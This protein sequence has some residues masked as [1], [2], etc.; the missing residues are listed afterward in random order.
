LEN[1]RIEALDT[2]LRD[3]AQCEGVSFSHDDMLS[4]AK[5]LDDFGITYIEA[6]C[7]DKSDL[8][9]F[10]SGLKL[11]AARLCAF[12]STRR[13]DCDCK[14]DI[15]L[16][17]LIAANTDTVSIVGKTWDFQVKEILK[18][19]LDENI[20][21]IGSSVK[22]LKSFKKY[23]IFDAEHFFDAY[24]NN[25]LYALK[26]IETAVKASA[27]LI[28]L[29]D[30][31]GG[32]HPNKIAAIVKEICGLYPDK[33]IGIHCHNDS[34]FAVINTVIAVENGATHIQGTFN[35]IGERCGNANLSSIIP[36]L[37]LKKGY[38]I[39]EPNKMQLLTETAAK[40]SD[41]SNLTLSPYSP[42]VGTSAFTHKAGLHA[43]GVLKTAASFE[44]L[45]PE[46][47]GNERRFLISELSGRN[48]IA[49]KIIKYFPHL[50]S[51][52]T[53]L[54]RIISKLKEIENPDYLFESAEASFVLKIRRLLFDYKEAFS[55]ES[56][57]TKT[58][59]LSVDKTPS[60]AKVKITVSDKT[61]VFNAFGKGPVDA[62]NEAFKKALVKFYPDLNKLTLTDYK[63]RVLDSKAATK[64][65]VR[66]LITT[67]DGV[68]I[69]TTAGVS[70]DI[71]K[72][73][74]DALKDSF[75]YKLFK[76]T[77]D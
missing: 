39:V 35:G 36:Y 44:H 17:N 60:E 9:F 23:V 54:D 14:N 59:D 69:W 47:V 74:F 37:Q 68:N 16:N 15:G 53:E 49:A 63:V 48:I 12:S 28:C 64:A 76:F 2:T 13:K 40:I 3:G 73:S 21:M 45:E 34:D 27:D 26:T 29:C 19:T 46:L 38:D 70:A 5:Y 41:V 33:K 50:K 62:L 77:S 18:T 66:V 1:L 57:E 65:T 11:K 20:N 61:E 71:I 56:F 30:T 75:E 55:V 58:S 32:T 51:N 8:A 24:L 4:I 25:K 22:Y 7:F 72:A 42:Y 31:N 6:P 10:N 52:L 67:T 43:D